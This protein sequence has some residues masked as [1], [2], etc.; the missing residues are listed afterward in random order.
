MSQ[1]KIIAITK[2]EVIKAFEDA[3]M[4]EKAMKAL[5]FE[6]AETPLKGT[7]VSFNTDPK[8][9]ENSKYFTFN[10]ENSEGVKVG[11]VSINRFFDSYVEEKKFLVVANGDNKG[12][13]M[14]KPLRINSLSRFGTSR[15][16][17]IANLVGKSYTATKVGKRVL[18]SYDIADIFVPAD[19]KG[20]VSATNLA[21]L[22]KNTDPKDLIEF[23]FE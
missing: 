7:I 1:E 11:E 17:Q 2:D 5:K 9:Y 4:S 18:K 21:K 19:T 22:W 16:D 3:G 15:A 13:A 20:E 12:K 23:T 14:L 10:V 6:V 8:V